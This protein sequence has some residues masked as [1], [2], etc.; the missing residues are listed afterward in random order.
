MSNENESD[1]IPVLDLDS[2]PEV[3]TGPMQDSAVDIGPAP[4]PLASPGYGVGPLAAPGYGT[5]DRASQLRGDASASAASTV[6][7][8]T[9]PT[10]GA[11]AARLAEVAG[12]AGRKNGA[13]VA[14]VN[15]ACERHV[16]SVLGGTPAAILT[17]GEAYKARLLGMLLEEA[18]VHGASQATKMAI[19]TLLAYVK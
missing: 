17:G 5:P 1:G 13:L 3:A 10:G 15:A 6:A 8:L 9:W 14:G 4:D 7:Y 19:E 12:E 11:V 16:V 2:M 18:Y